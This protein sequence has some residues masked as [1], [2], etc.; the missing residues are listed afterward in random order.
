MNRHLYRIV[1]NK[2]RGLLMVAAERAI[3]RSGTSSCR[4][5]RCSVSKGVRPS[6][7]AAV[8]ATIASGGAPLAYADILA[9]GSAAKSQQPTIIQTASGRP[10]VNIQTPNGAGV[11][12]NVIWCF[13]KKKTKWRYFDIRCSKQYICC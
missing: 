2:A 11:S 12:H 13:D 9:D 4:S 7:L 5:K 8:V 3:S 1:F 10:Q 6:V